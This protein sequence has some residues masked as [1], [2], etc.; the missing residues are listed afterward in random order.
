MI[1]VKTQT[2]IHYPLSLP[3]IYCTVLYL[4]LPAVS[5]A[6]SMANQEKVQLGAARFGE[7]LPVISTKKVGIVVN[8]TSLVDGVHLVYPAPAR[9]QHQGHLRA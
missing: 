8:Q 5:F 6:Q 7:Y 2:I 4:L 1:Y 9:H 3:K